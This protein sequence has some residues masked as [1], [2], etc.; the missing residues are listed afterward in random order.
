MKLT[1][2]QVG[3]PTLARD[4]DD[5]FD[6]IF[7]AP[8]AFPALTFE[9]IRKAM[10][11]TWMPAIDLTETEKEFILRAEIPGI[12]KENLDVHLEGGVLT[13]TGHRETKTTEKDENMLWEER[14]AGKF[15]RTIR[16]PK[17]VE[18]NKVDAVY[19]DGILTVRVPKAEVA[20][21]NKILIKG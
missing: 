10:E 4:F 12:P 15:V 17:P 13:V 1:K 9:P 6:R 7:N 3:T 2:P 8:L 11:G 20:V 5:V 21:K 18:P 19:A 14:E 16:L